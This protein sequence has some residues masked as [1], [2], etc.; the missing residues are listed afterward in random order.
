[1]FHRRVM[2]VLLSQCNAHIFQLALLKRCDPELILDTDLETKLKLNCLMMMYLHDRL[3]PGLRDQANTYTEFI[4]YYLRVVI[5]GYTLESICLWNELTAYRTHRNKET[6]FA[7]TVGENVACEYHLPL[8]L[9]FYGGQGVH[10][11]LCLLN[12]VENILKQ[13]NYCHCIISERFIQAAFSPID[14]FLIQ[15]FGRGPIPPFELYDESKPCAVC[16]EELSVT[17]NQGKSIYRRLAD[18]VCDHLTKKYTV[19]V[20]EDDMRKGL[21]HTPGFSHRTLDALCREVDAPPE[22]PPEQEIVKQVTAETEQLLNRYTIF[23]NIPPA[24]Y[25]ISELKYWLSSGPE[26]N[27]TL[28][29]NYEKNILG[30]REKDR[31]IRSRERV[32]ERQLFGRIP[33]HLHTLME[34]DEDDV[35][36]QIIVGSPRLPPE[37]QLEA[38][39]SACYAHHMNVPLFRRLNK[40]NERNTHALEK[41]LQ[42]VREGKMEDEE[43]DS[44]AP[45]YVADRG[46][47]ANDMEALEACVRDETTA[48]K[49]M[50]ASQLSKKS[51]ICLN[52][53][54]NTQQEML[55]KMISVNLYGESLLDATVKVKNGFLIRRL[56]LEWVRACEQADDQCGSLTD[57]DNRQYVRN[58]I[59]RHQVD[60]ALMPELVNQ[61]FSLINGPMFTNSEHTFAQPPNTPFYFSVENVGLLPHIKEE[62]SKFMLVSGHK[63]WMRTNY[64][65]FY[66]FVPGLNLNDAQ[67]QAW[68]Y[69][70]ELILALTVFNSI[71]HCG[72]VRLHRADKLRVTEEG[73]VVENGIYL[74]YERECPLVIIL[75]ASEGK[76]VQSTVVILESDIYTALYSILQR[77][78]TV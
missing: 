66:T 52:R 59:L 5:E 54:I 57:Y 23:S 39:I 70:R 61:F 3:L 63:E 43:I 49:K 18:C 55:H 75:G 67:T 15:T 72:G 46:A 9:E 78:K 22:T 10:K 68:V 51:F 25:K 58:A 47:V 19:N 62:L 50:Y 77:H 13:I 1:M 65:E 6:Y 73:P 27:N 36:G 69:I 53:C 29:D 12:D 32:V 8:E 71:Y 35:I 34:M 4:S 40:S 44:G 24:V 56:F 20:A 74:T 76:I 14:T 41:I 42:N 2:L 45:D 7:A 64:K 28:V 30:L 17:A 11:E 38:L 60:T 31:I 33:V 21:P 37:T 26:A 48:R 16:F